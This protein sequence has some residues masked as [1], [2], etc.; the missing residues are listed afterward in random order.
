MKNINDKELSLWIGKY[1]FPEDFTIID[2]FKSSYSLYSTTITRSPIAMLIHASHTLPKFNVSEQQLNQILLESWQELNIIPGAYW[3][4]VNCPDNVLQKVV[5]V[6][7][8]SYRNPLFPLYTRLYYNPAEEGGVTIV[9]ILGK[10]KDWM[11]TIE[12]ESHLNLAVYGSEVFC[13]KVKQ[14]VRD[15]NVI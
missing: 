12:L 15:V 8:Y 3:F 6:G 4:Q 1:L 5:A 10:N 7:I 9:G 13:E 2:Y 11:F 14:K